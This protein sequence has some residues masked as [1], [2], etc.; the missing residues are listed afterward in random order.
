MAKKTRPCCLYLVKSDTESDFRLVFYKAGSVFESIKLKRIRNTCFLAHYLLLLGCTES[1]LTVPQ[2][3][4]C[5]P[6]TT[7]SCP[8]TFQQH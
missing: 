2:W 8:T 5:R 7:R 6:C 3:S 1:L 4:G